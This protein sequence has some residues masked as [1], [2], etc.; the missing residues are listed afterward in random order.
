MVIINL[1]F[2]R[3]GQDYG[4]QVDILIFLQFHKAFQL[5]LYPEIPKLYQSLHR[6]YVH[7]SLQEPH[8]LHD[9]LQSDVF[10]PFLQIQTE[11]P[12]FIT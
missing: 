1:F 11:V 7:G 6:P 3:V 10:L 9:F 2:L 8:K 4:P 5:I 12:V